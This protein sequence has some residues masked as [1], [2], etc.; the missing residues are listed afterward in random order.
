M[1]ASGEPLS[2]FS[3]LA[4]QYSD[5]P[6]RGRTFLPGSGVLPAAVEAAAADLAENQ[7]S[8]ILEADSGFYLLLRKPLDTAGVAD[9]YFDSL[10]LSAAENAEVTCGEAYEALDVPYFYAFF[11][12][13]AQAA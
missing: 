12:R 6:T 3:A 8:G 5:D 2:L 10:L 4:E 7:W 11:Q 13:I 9:S 1:N